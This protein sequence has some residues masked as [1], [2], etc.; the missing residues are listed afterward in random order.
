MRMSKYLYFN[1]Y[2]L[3]SVSFEVVF[4]DVLKILDLDYVEEV[5][6]LT[7]NGFLRH[8][9]S[10]L[11]GSVLKCQLCSLSSNYFF[12]NNQNPKLRIIDLGNYLSEL[13]TEKIQFEFESLADVKRLEFQGINIGMGAV[14]SYVSYTRNMTPELD[15][16]KKN[17]FNKLLN[18]NVKLVYALNYLKNNEHLDFNDYQIKLFNGRFSELRTFFNYFQGKLNTI[19][20]VYTKNKDEVKRVEFI[21]SLPHSI[22]ENTKRINNN[23]SAYREED[24]KRISID[25][26]NRKLN[27]RSFYDKNYTKDQKKNLL[28]ENFDKTINNISYFVSSEDEVFAIGGRWDTDKIFKRQIDFLD[29]WIANFRSEKKYHLYV[30]MHPNM[31]G[32][33]F[34][35]VT[36]YLK[37]KERNISIIEPESKVSSYALMFNSN[38]VIVSSSS[39]GFEANY[40]NKPVIQIGASFYSELKVAHRPR[41]TSELKDMILDRNL[42]SQDKLESM[43]MALYLSLPP[44][45]EFFQLNSTFSKSKIFKYEFKRSSNYPKCFFLLNYIV[46]FLSIKSMVFKFKI[47]R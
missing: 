29:F 3:G 10:N 11:E 13:K 36:D 17:F 35:Y 16:F 34:S 30:R 2:R 9:S 43:K 21:N 27:D 15:K 45:E 23:W 28:P 26:F 47:R 22:R 46:R 8:C 44:S 14:S 40:F 31:K 12:K 37:Y 32:L 25:F 7:C 6:V 42:S 4:D 1:P 19:E 5:I 39:M 18:A 24:K 20:F 33:S 38:K 41:N